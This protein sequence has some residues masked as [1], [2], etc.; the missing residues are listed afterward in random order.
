MA[1]RAPWEPELP[2]YGLSSALSSTRNGL[3]TG[4]CW[5]IIRRDPS[6]AQ[7]P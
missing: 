6:M 3:Q 1:S 5:A 2:G 7:A 4:P